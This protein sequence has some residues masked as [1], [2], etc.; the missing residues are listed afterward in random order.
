MLA[1]C[2]TLLRKG[3]LYQLVNVFAYLKNKHK[4]KL[5]F[6]LPYPDIVF[7]QY[8]MNQELEKFNRMV[9]EDIP[10][11]LGK[12]FILRAYVDAKYVG[13]KL[14]RRSSTGYIV[15]TNMAPIYWLS[16]KQA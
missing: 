8:E 12:E 4:T 16:K 13:D 2:M 15:F 7:D 1:L 5:V 14:M 6:D 11:S 10:E 3:N 9:I